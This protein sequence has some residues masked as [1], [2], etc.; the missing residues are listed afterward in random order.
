MAGLLRKHP[1]RMEGIP[2]IR[3]RDNPGYALDESAEED[4]SLGVDAEDLESLS[5]TAANPMEKAIVQLTRV[6]T[7]LAKPSAKKSNTIEQLLDGSGLEKVGDGFGSTGAQKNAIAL[8][9]LRRCLVDQPEYIYSIVE[10]AMALDFQSRAL[11]PGEPLQAGTVRGWLESRSR[12]TNHQAH[13]RWVWAVGA[14]WDALIIQNNVKEAR[15]RCALM[16]AAADQTSIDA[17]SWVLSGVAL[18]E[19]PPPFHSFA[20]HQSPT[21]QEMNIHLYWIQGGWSSS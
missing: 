13:V 1:Q 15:A 6:C 9:A 21:P 20:P 17:G 7:A 14:I 5:Q 10:N 18:L 16:V 2:R 3:P 8:R 19:P 11:R 12:I 4:D